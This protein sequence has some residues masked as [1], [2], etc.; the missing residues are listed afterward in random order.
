[1]DTLTLVVL[2]SIAVTLSVADPW[3][4]TG[5]TDFPKKL[6]Q[7][8]VFEG[9]CTDGKNFIMNTKYS[10]FIMDT[11]L[12]VLAT[13]P[14]AI[15]A[16]LLVEGYNHLGDCVCDESSLCYY[17][18]EEP[19]KTKPSIFV[20]NL[21]NTG[22]NFVKEKHERIQSHM[23]WV[24][25]D[26]ATN[27]LYS[28]EFDEVGEMRVYSATTLEY[29]HSLP[30][31]GEDAP[32]NGVQGGAFYN[33]KLYVGINAGD[34]VYEIDVSTGQMQLAIQQYPE[35]SSGEYEF[36]GLTFL[37]LRAEGKGLM[38]NTGNHLRPQVMIHADLV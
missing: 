2:C 34:S 8:L 33:G 22:L 31:T 5:T 15:P 7:P 32:L 35:E 1:M 16:N 38:H 10:I 3:E 30:I 21:T 9:L 18:V 27:Y 28:S 4:V 36:E 14:S 20:Y 25:L 24:A 12:N 19:S 13:T 6:M 17:A 37:D 23:P 26:P 29:L 11:D